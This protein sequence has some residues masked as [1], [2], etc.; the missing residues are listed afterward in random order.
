MKKLILPMVAVS[1]LLISCGGGDPCEDLS[2]AENA[3]K[4]FCEKTTEMKALKK[5][6]DKEAGMKLHEEMEKYEDEIEKF[7]DEGKYTENE[8]ETA[9]EAID[10]CDL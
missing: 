7:I 2:T 5:K 1:F 10:G 4:C 3:A 8:L 9:A 6:D